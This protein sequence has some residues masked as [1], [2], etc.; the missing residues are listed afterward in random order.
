MSQYSVHFSTLVQCKTSNYFMQNTATKKAMHWPV[1]WYILLCILCS[2]QYSVFLLQPTSYHD[3]AH[4]NLII[5]L[6]PYF[7]LPPFFPFPFFFLLL[8]E[9]TS[10][11]TFNLANFS[12]TSLAVGWSAIALDELASSTKDATYA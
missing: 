8:I 6:F 3:A 12:A 11:R 1:L 7:F 4:Q 10:P 5:I 2:I 9:P